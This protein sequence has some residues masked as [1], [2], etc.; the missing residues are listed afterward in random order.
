MTYSHHVNVR[1]VLIIDDND[2]AAQLL[3]MF[4]SVLGNTAS[5]A[6][7]GA[8]GLALATIFQPDIVF[9]DLGMPGMS[10]YE[11]APKLRQIAGLEKVYITALTGWGDAKT[12]QQVIECGFD[13]HLVKPASIELIQKILVSHPNP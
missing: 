8:S 2:D 10:G 5:V 11:V 12:R 13:R 7:S 3:S 4:V 1:R 9:L 6:N